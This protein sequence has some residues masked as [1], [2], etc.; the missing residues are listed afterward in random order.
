MSQE[1]FE[2]SKMNPDD[3]LFIDKRIAEF[4]ATLL[5]A[6]KPPWEI[7]FSVLGIGFVVLSGLYALVVMPMNTRL[8]KLETK[9]ETYSD[10]VTKE[11]KEMFKHWDDLPKRK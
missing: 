10:E 2:G 8:D 6:Q 1:N 7:I 11:H 4:E 3:Q 9:L 5:R